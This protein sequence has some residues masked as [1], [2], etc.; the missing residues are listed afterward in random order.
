VRDRAE[1]LRHWQKVRSLVASL[2]DSPEARALGVLACDALLLHGLF[3]G[4]RDEES[5]A[6]FAEGMTLASGREGAAPRL[7][8]L[9]RFGARNALAGDLDAAEP[10]LTEARH[11]G[12]ETGD[13]LLQFIPRF[14]LVGL[15]ASQGRLAET[16]ALI[17]ELEARCGRDPEFGAFFTGFSPY[18]FLLSQRSTVLLELGRPLDAAREAARALEVARG[19]RDHEAVV[20]ASLGA[21]AV[22]EVLGSAAEAMGHARDAA[23]AVEGGAEGLRQAFLQGLGRA[24]LLAGEWNDA[25]AAHEQ[26]L[27]LIRERRTGLALEG[28]ILA[29]LAEA[30]LG[31]GDLGRARA[32]AE[33][34]V[35]VCRRRHTRAREAVA[36]L[37][38]ARV[39]IADGPSSSADR[40]LID[41]VAAIDETGARLYTPFVHVERARL[42]RR[43][44][45]EAACADELGEAKRLFLAMG[46][47][48][49]AVQAA[50]SLDAAV[51][52]G[53]R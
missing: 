5:R 17:D 30:H 44:G 12:D 41:A 34:A 33:E 10:L 47:T 1:T 16:L 32:H 27:A 48:A 50:R 24:H 49:C 15:R 39:G 29:S 31:A 3:A 42:A 4:Q 40:D 7:R 9:T 18:A 28:T 13:A 21:V 8:L 26:A 6:L 25:V 35:A 22:C 52:L 51:R 46:A 20:I 23:A 38:R 53:G 2:P 37:A 11:L 36:L 14:S 19:R 45:D 43:L